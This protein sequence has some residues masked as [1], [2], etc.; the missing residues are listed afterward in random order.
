VI[1]SG[2]EQPHRSPARP[3]TWSYTNLG[4]FVFDRAA[5]EAALAHRPST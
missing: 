4:P 2:F 5:Y 3:P 1:W